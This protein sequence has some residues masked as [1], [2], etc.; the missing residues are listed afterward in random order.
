[1]M[2]A[3]ARIAI[4]RA[5]MWIAFCITPP[6]WAFRLGSSRL[7]G[8]SWIDRTKDHRSLADACAV[9]AERMRREAE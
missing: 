8:W 3:E 1:M 7:G 2:V 5:V 9:A 4:A 6:G